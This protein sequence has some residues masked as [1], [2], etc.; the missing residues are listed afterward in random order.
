VT[1]NPPCKLLEWDSDF[2]GARIAR[3]ENHHLSVE[4]I[5]HILQWCGENRMDCLYFLCAPDDDESVTIAE[6]AGFHLVDIRI[7]LSCSIPDRPV[8]LASVRHFSEADLPELK[9]IAA[10]AFTDSRFCYDRNFAVDK[11]SALYQ[12]WVDKSCRDGTVAVF[13]A[14]YQ[15]GIGGFITCHTE[16]SNMGRIGL[17]GVSSNARGTGLGDTL[18]KAALNYFCERKVTEARIVTQGRNLAA[19]RLYQANGFRICSINLWYHKWFS[20][21]R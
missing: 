4:S 1:L 8:E 14:E 18:A 6:N 19:Q 16:S 3:V 15:N 10:N 20:D 11:V 9:K 12:E 17:V 2:F 13:I 21:V 7:E 5:D